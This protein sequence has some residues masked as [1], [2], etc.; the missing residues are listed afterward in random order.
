MKLV[1]R[2]EAAEALGVSTWFVSSMKRAGA[3]FWGRRT[4]VA[5]LAKWLLEHPNFIAKRTWPSRPESPLPP[6]QHPRA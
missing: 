2:T 5:A 4:C 3:P 6:A 1:S